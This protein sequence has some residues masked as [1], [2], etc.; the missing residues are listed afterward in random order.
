MERLQ[1]V[2]ANSGFTSRRKAEELIKNGKVM[3]N[4]EEWSQVST[5]YD[6]TEDRGTEIRGTLED[7]RVLPEH[8][9]PILEIIY[10]EAEAYF[11]GSKTIE[12][13]IPTIENRVQL[14]L[15]EKK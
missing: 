6:M 4:G 1:K 15:D 11:A 10:E 8:T 13:I 5:L 3:V 7:A 2:I 12:E 9:Q 14:Y